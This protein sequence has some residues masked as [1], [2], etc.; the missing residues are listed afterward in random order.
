MAMT[1]FSEGDFDLKLLGLFRS[2]DVDNG[3]FIDRQELLSMLFSAIFGLCKLL[4]LKPPTQDQVMEYSYSVFKEID[5]DN[6]GEID[7]EEFSDWVRNNVD[8]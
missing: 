7:C 5:G 6:S 4:D 8:L 3:G 2:F 1:V